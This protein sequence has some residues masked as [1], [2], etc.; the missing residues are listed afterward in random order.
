MSHYFEGEPFVPSWPESGRLPQE[1]RFA[2][3]RERERER[4]REKLYPIL[5]GYRWL[6]IATFFCFVVL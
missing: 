2:D 6:T 3:Q 4:E 5:E 1:R